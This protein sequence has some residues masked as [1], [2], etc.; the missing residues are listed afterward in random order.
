MRLGMLKAA[1]ESPSP[2]TLAATGIVQVRWRDVG[3][4]RRCRRL[5]PL[6]MTRVL[7]AHGQKRVF[8]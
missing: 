5:L 3:G 7:T 8:W 4:V 1:K 6:D 2:Q